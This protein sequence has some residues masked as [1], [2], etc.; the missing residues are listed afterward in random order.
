MHRS[1]RIPAPFLAAA[2]LLAGPALAACGGERAAARRTPASGNPRTPATAAPVY[3]PRRVGAALL[4]AGDI[5]RGVTEIP[6]GTPA[7]ARHAVPSCSLAIIEPTGRPDIVAHEFGATHY[8]GA[9]FGQISLT[10]PDAAAASSMFG[11]IRTRTAACPATR[12]VSLTAPGRS[13]AIAHDD[14][15]R[16]S[17]D[18]VLGWTRLRGFEK[19]VYPPS[20]SVLNVLYIAYD[21]VARGNVVIASMYWERVRPNVSGGTVADTATRLL[22]RQL[23]KLG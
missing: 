19:D 13:V 14:T 3:P 7:L 9:H 23:T 11:V 6:L 18:G 5:G 4:S 2:L 8:T 22:T 17:E 16:I 10:Y 15:W 20:S 21:Y 1:L 12:H